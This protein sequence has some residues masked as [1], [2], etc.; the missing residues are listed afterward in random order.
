MALFPAVDVAAKE[1][2]I[3]GLHAYKPGCPPVAGIQIV[4]PWRIDCSE[5]SRHVSELIDSQRFDAVILAA[6]WS[7]YLKPGVVKIPD[8][9]AG[10]TSGEFFTSQLRA[11]INELSSTGNGLCRR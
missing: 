2:R 1:V 7:T 10:G 3:I 8:G 5:F 9:Y 6:A 11:G 4:H